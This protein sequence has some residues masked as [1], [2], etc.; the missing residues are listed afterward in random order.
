MG[1]AVLSSGG[2]TS[3]VNTYILGSRKVP[4][5]EGHSWDGVGVTL[6]PLELSLAGGVCE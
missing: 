1:R 2:W 6:G 4:G 5:W 3:S